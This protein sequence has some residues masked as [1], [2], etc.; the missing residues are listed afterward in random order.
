MGELCKGLLRWFVL[1]HWLPR[2]NAALA[3]QAFG[4]YAEKSNRTP[5]QGCGE[6]VEGAPEGGKELDTF[7]STS[8]PKTSDF[9]SLHCQEGF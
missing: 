3:N 6:E 8:F 7:M 4:P 5:V 2:A 9:F 1:G